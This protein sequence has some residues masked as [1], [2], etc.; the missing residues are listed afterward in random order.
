MRGVT[1]HNGA[2]PDDAS[3]ERWRQRY[4]MANVALRL[5]RGII[6]LDVDLY[7]PQGRESWEAA[8][9]AFGPLP[10]TWISTS[11][12]DGSGIR[13]Y[14]VPENVEFKSNPFPGIETIQHHHRFVV[15]WPSVHPKTGAE[16]RWIAPDGSHGRVPHIEEIPS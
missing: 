7:K 6:G 3:I 15:C 14:R 10:D 8:Q 16:Y 4:P 12:D 1:G 9:E 5:P 13:L 11:K 2:W